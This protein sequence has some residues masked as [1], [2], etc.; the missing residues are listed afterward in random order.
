M[1]KGYNPQVAD[2]VFLSQQ[3][4]TSAIDSSL[5]KAGIQDTAFI[6]GTDSVKK[7]DKYILDSTVVYTSTIKEANIKIQFKTDSSETDSPYIAIQEWN[8]NENFLLENPIANIKFHKRNDSLQ[9]TMQYE[10]QISSANRKTHQNDW[11][12]GLG[13]LIIFLFIWIRIFYGKFYTILGDSISNYQIA[14]K[15]YDEKNILTR[16]ASLMLNVIYFIVFAIFLYE[17]FI[18]FSIPAPDIKGTYLFGIILGV[19]FLYSLIRIALLQMT[20]FIFNNRSVFAEYI[21]HTIPNPLLN[22]Y[23]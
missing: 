11:L 5:I 2:S 19:L 10:N 4:D 9:T 23:V 14:A 18:H 1:Q 3:I 21:H 15:L 16:R 17:L 8:F 22:I 7:P 20:G 6:S 12:T 13:L